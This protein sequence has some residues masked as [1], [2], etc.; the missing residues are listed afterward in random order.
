MARETCVR[1]RAARFE[2]GTRSWGQIGPTAA[3]QGARLLRAIYNYADRKLADDL[4]TSPCVAVEFLK[5]RGTRRVLSWDELPGWW[6][7]VVTLGNPVRRVLLEAAAV[8]WAAHVGRGYDRWEDVR[9]NVLRRPNPKGGRRPCLRPAAYFAAAHVFAEAR[10][11]AERLHQG[12]LGLPAESACGH[13][14]NMRELKAFPGV[15]PHDLSA[16]LRHGL[17]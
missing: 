11:A 7:K 2:L 9:G 5:E 17:C 14:T 12:S 8:V 4:P 13:V 3:N 15:W 16:D 1:S 10:E 6:D